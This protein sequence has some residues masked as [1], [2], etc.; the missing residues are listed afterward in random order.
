M[1]S[2]I[3]ENE[4]DQENEEFETTPEQATGLKPTIF[5]R[6]KVLIVICI[7]FAVIVCGGLIL[8]TLKSPS[9]KNSASGDMEYSIRQ[10]SSNEFLNSLQN[11]AVNRRVS[12]ENQSDQS[13][14]PALSNNEDKL[15]KEPEPLLPAVSF[16]NSRQQAVP[17]ALAAPQQ[18]QFYQPPSSSASYPS[19][20]PPQAQETHYRSS[21]IPQIQG[22]LFSNNMQQTAVQPA[23]GRPSSDEL[24]ANAVARYS[25][26]SNQTVNN[27]QQN[28]QSNKQAFYDSST[29][30]IIYNGTYLGEN[31]I[32]AG[33]VIPGVLETAINT[34]LPGNVL[35]RVTQNIFDSQ[36][37]KKLLI[38]QGTILIAKYNS[39]ISFAQHRVQIVWDTMIRPDGLQ[40]DLEGA[41]GV[42]KSGM[43]G[44]TAKYDENWFEYLKAAGIITL[45]SVA[46]AR[47]TDS[48]AKYAEEGASANIA[49]ANAALVNQLGGNLASRA[50]NIQPTLT[51]TNG[52]VI[53]VMLN[54]TLFLP[55][56]PNYPATQKYILE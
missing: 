14:I 49:E 18:Q 8:N 2:V 50:M 38:P 6:K 11:R 26:S 39:S 35:A 33:T 30:G 34:D 13:N 3:I 44:Q 20:Q 9:K 5:N 45:F 17:A 32:W 23:N 55:S 29:G 7:S 51:V 36:T 24:Y 54:K 19:S 10:T 47:M 53:N 22:S 31:T 46:N 16:E 52:T 43:S 40:I 21:L 4:E 56:V 12:E 41:N 48:A 27:I 42:D 1:S 25:S 15:V 37:G 28:D